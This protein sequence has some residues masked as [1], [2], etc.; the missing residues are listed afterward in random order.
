M[1]PFRVLGH[2]LML[3]WH[4]LLVAILCQYFELRLSQFCEELF[5]GFCPPALFLIV[6]KHPSS[7]KFGMYCAENCAMPNNDLT[8]DTFEDGVIS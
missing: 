3:C 4:K 6:S 8:S 7:A 1:T 5:F 2:W